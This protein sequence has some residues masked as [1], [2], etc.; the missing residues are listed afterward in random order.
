MITSFDLPRANIIQIRYA[1][2]LGSNLSAVGREI[3][4]QPT[5]AGA[6]LEA[7]VQTLGLGM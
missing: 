1:R 4:I 5:E 6:T 7:A 3:F 2:F